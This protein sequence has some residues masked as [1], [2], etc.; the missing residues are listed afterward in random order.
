MLV[1]H[2]MVGVIFTVPAAIPN[3]LKPA[4]LHDVQSTKTKKFDTGLAASL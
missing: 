4:S 2:A 1:V 3:Q